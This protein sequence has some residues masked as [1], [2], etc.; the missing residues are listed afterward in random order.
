ME[1]TQYILNRGQITC[2]VLTKTQKIF[3][4]RLS[5]S[6]WPPSQKKK[7]KKEK[8]P[9]SFETRQFPTK[10]VLQKKKKNSKTNSSFNL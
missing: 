1:G 10:S 5:R 2:T 4:L 3:L 9:K 7:K 6:L 8:V